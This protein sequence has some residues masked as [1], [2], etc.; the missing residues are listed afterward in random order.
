[1][2][3][4][5]SRTNTLFEFTEEAREVFDSYGVMFNTRSN[6]LRVGNDA[7]AAAEEGIVVVSP[8]C[9]AGHLIPSVVGLHCVPHA[10][11]VCIHDRAIV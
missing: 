6:Q 4:T 11:S 10:S 5:S 3:F 2:K 7:D 9:V 8:H 1:M